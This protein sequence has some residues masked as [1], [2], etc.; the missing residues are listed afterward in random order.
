[1]WR[2]PGSPEREILNNLQF[3]VVGP[4]FGVL[5][6]IPVGKVEVSVTTFLHD[7]ENDVIAVFIHTGLIVPLDLIADGKFHPVDV[8]VCFLAVLKRLP[9]LVS[10]ILGNLVA[11]EP[12]E[13]VDVRVGRVCKT[14]LNEFLNLI[15]YALFNEDFEGVFSAGPSIKL[16]KAT[17]NFVLHSN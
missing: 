6:L 2:N 4:P 8:L 10:K 7:G 14:L 11:F 9:I 5:I 17:L 12:Q 13:V 16:V 1:M 15:A 3:G